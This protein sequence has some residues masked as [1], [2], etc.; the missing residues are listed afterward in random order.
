MSSALP[1]LKDQI[2]QN[3][4][5]ESPTQILTNHIAMNM[6]HVSARISLWT[7]GLAHRRLQF[8]SSDQTIEIA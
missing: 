5:W 3:Q 4:N 7:K 1:V 8:S 6:T 2:D